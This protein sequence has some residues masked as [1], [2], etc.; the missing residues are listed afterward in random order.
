MF[1]FKIYPK[2]VN[3]QVRSEDKIKE[4]FFEENGIIDLD[5]YRPDG[6]KNQIWY[7]IKIGSE[8]PLEKDWGRGRYSK[9]TGQRRAG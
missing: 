7:E 8:M 1:A 9:R 5:K 4:K 2:S 6:F 3:N